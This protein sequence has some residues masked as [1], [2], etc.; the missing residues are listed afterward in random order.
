M[1]SPKATLM[2]SD[3]EDEVVVNR[4]NMIGNGF[5][6]AHGLKSSFKDFI[7]NYL[8]SIIEIFI[9]KKVYSD[10]LIQ[11]NEKLDK[12]E[13]PMAYSYEELLGVDKSDPE[14][15]FLKFNRLIKKYASIN[16]ASLFFKNTYDNIENFGW[17][18]IE[19][20]Y[21]DLLKKS[22]QNSDVKDA[23]K[24]INSLNS[25]LEFLKDKLI[26]Y[27]R[28]EQNKL[29]KKP[30]KP[31]L[32]QLKS[33]IRGIDCIDKII[34]KDKSQVPN[35]TFFLNFNYTKIA[36]IYRDQYKF[37]EEI[38]YTYSSH[39]PHYKESSTMNYIHGC[40]KEGQPPIFGFGDEMDK[41][42]KTF[43]NYKIDEAF[44]HIKSFKYLESDS[45]RRLLEFMDGHPFQ[46]QIFGHSCG[47]SDRTMLNTI[48]EHENCISIKSY[49]Y[50]TELEND[51]T[52]KNFSI[53]RHFE[54]KK[55]L[56]KKVV[57]FELCDPMKQPDKKYKD[58]IIIKE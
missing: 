47:I 52:R 38:Y 20:V 34:E 33:N 48:F 15:C 5:D 21:F 2:N 58:E 31:L 30:Y 37:S 13:T 26:D 3:N 51:F 19:V 22:F 43:E 36:Q 27:L 16:W 8:I 11:I 54:D 45:Y 41:D 53:A 42:Y 56:R 1:E 23:R 39:D 49:Y 10:I 9:D 4:I 25:E 6:M 46:V 55:M 7:G 17:V 24:D 12:Q 28:K 18:D 35:H 44:D 40:I 57:N 29:K 32:E 50:E 14:D